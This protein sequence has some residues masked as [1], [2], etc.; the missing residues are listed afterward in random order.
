MKNYIMTSS[1]KSIMEHFLLFTY[2]IDDYMLFLLSLCDPQIPVQKVRQIFFEFLFHDFYHDTFKFSDE[3]DLITWLIWF[4][5]FLEP[6]IRI[7]ALTVFE[8]QNRKFTKFAP[9]W[10]P[11]VILVWGNILIKGTLFYVDSI[12][13][14]CLFVN[15]LGTFVTL[16]CELL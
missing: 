16:N 3:S 1:Q 9:L 15:H 10:P 8:I 4:I 14:F 13:N 6:L 7:L 12:K 5:K 2:V 11:P